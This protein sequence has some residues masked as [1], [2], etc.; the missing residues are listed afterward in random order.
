[1]AG[2]SGQA[3][4]G[5]GS[6]VDV[7]DVGE[8]GVGRSERAVLRALGHAGPE[9]LEHWQLL[10]LSG[11]VVAVVDGYLDL[12]LRGFQFGR[13]WSRYL[14]GGCLELGIVERRL[15]VGLGV[16]GSVPE[17]CHPLFA[18]FACAVQ[19]EDGIG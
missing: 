2:L 10:A 11:A 13:G 18:V 1:M 16:E 7:V 3:G 5:V 12:G 6:A 8:T 17:E 19:G 15:D 9:Q 14:L 4:V